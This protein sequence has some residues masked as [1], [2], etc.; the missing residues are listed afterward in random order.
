MTGFFLLDSASKTNDF[1][2]PLSGSESCGK[3]GLKKKKKKRL[4]RNFNRCVF[5][6]SSHEKSMQRPTFLH[7]YLLVRRVP[8]TYTEP[9]VRSR[10]FWNLQRNLRKQKQPPLNFYKLLITCS[11][12]LSRDKGMVIVQASQ[13]LLNWAHQ[14]V[15]AALVCSF[16]LDFLCLDSL[17]PD[18]DSMWSNCINIS[19]I[20]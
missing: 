11:N 8:E 15:S 3:R 12:S 1:C 17:L 19:L 6:W 2:P 14:H 4:I 18:C 16:L 20:F 13:E 5:S 7:P 9:A 10:G